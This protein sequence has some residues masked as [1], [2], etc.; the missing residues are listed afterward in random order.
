MVRGR[1]PL[2]LGDEVHQ[3]SDAVMFKQMKDRPE[4]AESLVYRVQRNK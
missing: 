2:V 4:K 1:P 3:G